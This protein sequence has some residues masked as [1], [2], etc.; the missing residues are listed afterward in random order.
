MAT[1]EEVLAF[2]LDEIGPKGW[3]EANEEVDEAIRTRFKDSLDKARSGGLSMWMT[4]PSGAL[5]YI[6]LTDQFSRNMYRGSSEAFATDR[7]ALAMSK[8]AVDRGWD[9][10][11]DEPARQFFYMPMMHSECITD[12]ERCIRMFATRMPEGRDEHLLHAR[13]HRDVI[14]KFGRFPFRNE[15]LDRKTS[16][17]EV[18]F[19]EAGGYGA[20]V[21]E[22]QATA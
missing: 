19:L 9:L 21:R 17:P 15:A 11:I 3:Y 14:R 13:A 6:I 10:R 12:Q 2:W 8:I 7:L 1:P 5:A 16:E 22:I 18:A 20:T 4:Y